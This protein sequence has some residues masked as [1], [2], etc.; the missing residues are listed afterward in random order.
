MSA[1]DFSLEA[2]SDDSGKVAVVDIGS[3]TVRLVVYDAPTRLPIPMF[4]E[5]AQCELGRGLAMSGRLNPEGV[6]L[7]YDSLSRFINLSKAMGAKQLKMVATAAVRDAEDGPD[8][9]AEVK[10][11]FGLDIQVLRGS[12]EA[13]LAAIG[14]LSGVPDADGLVGDLGGGSLDL[15]SVNNGEFGDHGTLPLGH[16]RMAEALELGVEVAEMRI[17][18]NLDK[19]PWI[20]EAKGRTFYA[21]GGS[22]RALARIFIHQMNHPLHV[23]DNYTMRQLD[24]LRLSNLIAGLSEDSLQGIE[25]LALRRI[26]T[27]PPA[28]MV[29]EAMIRIIQPKNL[30]FSGF[31]MREGQLLELLP[32]KFSDKD[33]LLEACKS[34]SERI[35]RFALRGKEILRWMDPLFPDESQADRRLRFAACL[36]SDIGWNEHPDYR[37]EHAFHRVLRIPFAGLTHPERVLLAEAIF[38]RYNG[39][40]ASKLVSPVRS[41]LNAEQQSWV[42]IVGLGLRMGH[43]LSGSAPGLLE[44]T[45]LGVEDGKLKLS[46]PG[47]SG[48]FVSETVERRMRTLAAKLDLEAVID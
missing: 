24:A 29:M 36:L 3:N 44:K 35:G 41:I 47:N 40:P 45:N 15:V 2:T 48:M 32:E 16:L 30:V 14:L 23:V 5:K 9:V 7:A 4:N 34:F 10:K 8:F 11:R 42:N 37:A 6:T 18:E 13:K 31:G 39:D 12:E 1:T 33:P 25:R 21:I 26:Q 38:I 43:T 27:L 17:Q 46:V 22:W 20:K 28:A 19:L